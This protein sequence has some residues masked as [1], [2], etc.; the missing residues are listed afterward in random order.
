MKENDIRGI[1][2]FVLSSLWVLLLVSYVRNVEK[3]KKIKA[4]YLRLRVQN[5]YL[6][7]RGRELGRRQKR[8]RIIRHEMI[9]DYILETG[10]LERGLYQR[11]EKHYE[12]K[13]GYFGAK[14]KRE[15][16]D[17]GNVGMDAIL[18]HKLKEAEQEG[19]SIDFEHQVSG[20]V[21]IADADLNTVIGNLINNA[22]EAVRQMEL[23]ERKI[24]LKIRADQTTFFLEIRNSYQGVLRKDKKDEYLTQKSGRQFHGLGLLQIKRVVRKYGGKVVIKDKNGCFDVRLLFYM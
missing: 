10:Y 18:N 16:V 15:L 7:E 20:R 3:Y 2:F 13:A 21:K 19:I 17:T 12:K 14:G 8:L 5:A 22:M 6:K 23:E 11:L 9:N 4:D 1:L 24:I